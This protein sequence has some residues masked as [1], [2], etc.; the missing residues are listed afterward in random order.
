MPQ[1]RK[2]VTKETRVNLTVQAPIG[3]I[4]KMTAWAET[5][6]VSRG[7]IIRRCIRRYLTEVGEP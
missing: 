1:R 2:P 5:F 7:E 6:G 4:E 3:D